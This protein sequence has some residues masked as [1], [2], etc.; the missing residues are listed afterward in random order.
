MGIF[1][2]NTKVVSGSVYAIVGKTRDRNEAAE[3]GQQL[4]NEGHRVKIIKN[5]GNYEVLVYQGKDPRS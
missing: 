5:G 3:V 4:H 1:G 2:E